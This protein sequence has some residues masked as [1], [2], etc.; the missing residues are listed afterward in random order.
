MKQLPSAD[1]YLQEY[2]YWPWGKLI[3]DLISKVSDCAPKNG[4]VL[5]AICGPGYLLGK[6]KE[7]RP[8][9]DCT[10]F[11][12]S[13]PYIRHAEKSFPENHYFV[14]DA[15]TWRPKKKYDIVLCTSGVHHISY[16]RQSDLIAKL[17]TS[18]KKKGKCIIADPIIGFYNDEK[19]RQ[20]AAAKFGQ[21]NLAT[22]IKRGA[23]PE[24][25]ATALDVMHNDVMG[26]EYKD[27][28]SHLYC[29]YRDHFNRVSFRAHT[30]SKKAGGDFSFTCTH[31]DFW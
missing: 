25:I 12:I 29:L 16:D 5:D 14:Q 31:E 18:T 2:E 1:V 17:A 7:N 30:G 23:P 15:L 20:L 8:D 22:V 24:I 4:T 19:G 13:R 10:G 9:L 11:D 26:E 27:S 28:L 6:I 21:W 3:R